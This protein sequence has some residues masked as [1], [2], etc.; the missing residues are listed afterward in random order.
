LTTDGLYEE[1]AKQENILYER[2][3][4][5]KIENDPALKSDRIHPNAKGYALMAEAFSKILKKHKI[6]E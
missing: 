3:I 4:L 1:V 6:V 2:E 5:T